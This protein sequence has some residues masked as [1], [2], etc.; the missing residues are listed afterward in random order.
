MQFDGVPGHAPPPALAGG[1]EDNPLPAFSQLARDMVGDGMADGP[2][3]DDGVIACD[4]CGLAGIGGRVDRFGLQHRF[5]V[6]P[7]VVVGIQFHG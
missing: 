3:P 7:D 5:A 1:Q 4:Q 6:V 2:L